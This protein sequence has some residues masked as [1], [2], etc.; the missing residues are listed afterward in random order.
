MT[1]LRCL[2]LLLLF[3]LCFFSPGAICATFTIANNCG[4]TVWPGL[5]SGAGTVELSTTGFSLES[6]QSRAV[7]VNPSWSGRVW[8][9]THCSTNPSTGRFSCATGD[10]GSGKVECS[11]G[12]AAPPT[13]LAEFTLNGN[14]GM[15]FFDVS[16][17]DGYNLPLLITPQS[18]GGAA[19]GDC[20]AT[21]CAADINGI[22]PSGLGVILSDSD[23]QSIA[24]RSACSAFGTP[25]YCCSGAYANPNTCKPSSYSQFFKNACPQAYSY[26]YDDATSTFTC[27]TGISYLIS[28]CPNTNSQK[29]GNNKPQAAELSQFNDTMVFLR[30]DSSGGPLLARTLPVWGAA[31]ATAGLA[32]LWLALQ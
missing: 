16:L 9:R 1:T 24:C 21:G 2:L 20:S 26:A 4:Y 22:C 10:C 29:S 18:S 27:P 5:L 6:G 11:G 28:F 30:P 12:G 13:S 19:V 7:E 23:E 32:A 25:V 8:G 17:V 31:V 15:D 3:F 14:G